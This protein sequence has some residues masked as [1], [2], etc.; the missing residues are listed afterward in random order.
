MD[1]L[2]IALKEQ[3]DQVSFKTVY[4]NAISPKMSPVAQSAQ[5]NSISKS[6]IIW[7]GD[8]YFHCGV[9]VHAQKG[10]HWASTLKKFFRLA[11]ALLAL[12]GAPYIYLMKLVSCSN[13]IILIISFSSCHKCHSKLLLHLQCN[14]R[15]FTRL[16]SFSTPR[17]GQKA[18]DVGEVEVYKE[19]CLGQSDKGKTNKHAVSKNHKWQKL[20]F[21]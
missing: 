18:A 11:T 6:S 12:T 17:T 4:R 1:T 2:E 9:R 15:Q 5:L 8:C 3:L 16:S 14:S 20:S 13:L 7:S 21:H 19:V 10:E